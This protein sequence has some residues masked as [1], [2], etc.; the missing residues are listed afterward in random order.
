MTEIKSKNNRAF[1]F[2]L[3]AFFILF[4]IIFSYLYPYSADE[5]LYTYGSIKQVFSQ[6]F[7]SYKLWNPRLGLLFVS[8]VLYFGKWLFL[9]L[10]PLMQLALIFAEFYFVFLRL[11]DFNFLKDSV[12]FAMLMILSVFL[13]SSP[14]NSLFWIGGAC[15]YSWALLPFILLLCALRLLS[16]NKLF[17]KDNLPVFAA[18]SALGFMTGMSNENNAP[19]ALVIFTMFLFYALYKKRKLPKWFF[20]AFGAAAVGTFLLLT[21]PGSFSRSTSWEYA[22]FLGMPLGKRLFLWLNHMQ[23]LLTAQFYIPALLFIALPLAY[24]NKDAP[25]SPVKDKNLFLS[26]ACFITA[27]VLAFVLFMAPHPPERAFYSASVFYILSFVFFLKYFAETFKIRSYEFIFIPLV[28]AWT[29]LAPFA[30][31]PYIS[32]HI[33]DA[34]RLNVVKQLQGKNIKVLYADRF[35]ILSGPTKNLSLTYYD[36]VNF[37]PHI[38]KQRL[39]MPIQEPR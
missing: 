26:A 16:E 22:D 10:N 6:Y 1:W 28:A 29:I 12:P 3:C 15:N 7:L 18:A 4:I 33:Q 23:D 31:L 17:F 25:E 32:L 36:Y 35:K 8:I 21:A 24:L 2:L 20:F 30:A 37:K 19:M 27:S 39:G 5:Y 14:D 11:P 34:Q 13:I 9:I 38:I